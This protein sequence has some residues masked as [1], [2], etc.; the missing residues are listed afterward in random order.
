MLK[1]VTFDLWETLIAD[2]SELDSRRTEYR[3][4]NIHAL[5]L[6][7]RPG[8]DIQ[9]IAAAHEKTWQECSA[10]W[11]GSRD[12]A[13]FDQIRLF[14]GMIDRE[15]PALL[16]QNDFR[17]ISEIYAGAVMQYRPKLIEGARKTLD[18]L[19]SDG[20][21]AGLICNTGRTPGFMLRKLLED[22]G[23]FGFF[24]SALFSDETIIRKPDAEIFERSLREL[25]AEKLQTVHVGDSWEND[26]LGA[27]AAGI[28]AV[29]IS[30]ENNKR[31]DCPII[32]NISEL[33]DVIATL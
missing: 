17:E 5:L 30:P 20:Y 4:S 2:S 9:R 14:I 21:R 6:K 15:L 11:Q 26:I 32:K 28:K 18:L 33:P 27:R 22:Y 13:F 3:V 25:E 12:L 23:I 8:L 19:S 7:K 24:S 1:F 16:N 10:I 31:S 29:W